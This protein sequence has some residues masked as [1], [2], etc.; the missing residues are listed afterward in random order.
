MN[1]LNL[2]QVCKETALSGSQNDKN[3]HAFHTH[4]LFP[5]P[6][7]SR[8]ICNI[9]SAVSL[10]INE[11]KDINSYDGIRFFYVFLKYE[12]ILYRITEIHFSSC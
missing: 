8:N 12:E 3:Q 5:L 4:A 7:E 10:V 6:L 9:I 2:I 11:H 1:R